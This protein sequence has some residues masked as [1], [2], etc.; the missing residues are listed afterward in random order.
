MNLFISFKLKIKK[1]KATTAD[2]KIEILCIFQVMS[3]VWCFA[4][5][6]T[7]CVML[8]VGD[9]H[10]L[11]RNRLRNRDLDHDAKYESLCT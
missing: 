4:V 1:K 2:L 6:A 7:C 5:I 8:C 9:G 3:F 10:D 11:R